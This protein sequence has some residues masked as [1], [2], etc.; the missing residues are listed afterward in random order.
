MDEAEVDSDDAAFGPGKQRG[1]VTE[2]IAYIEQ[3]LE[4]AGSQQEFRRFYMQKLKCVPFQAEVICW[5]LFFSAFFIFKTSITKTIMAMNRPNKVQMNTPPKDL[6][7]IPSESSRIGQS[8]RF[9]LFQYLPIIRHNYYRT[10]FHVFYDI[11]DFQ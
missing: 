4:E 9:V 8:L 7:V 11:N 1:G 6:S 5:T 10:N 2:W 3:K